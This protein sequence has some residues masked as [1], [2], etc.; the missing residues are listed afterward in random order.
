MVKTQVIV[1]GMPTIWGQQHDPLT[2]APVSARSYEMVSL[3]SRESAAV[4]SFL[5][6]LPSPDARAIAAV[7]HAA[8]WF[9]AHEIFGYSYVPYARR[10][11]A[12]AGPLWARM[13][14]IGTN[15]PIFSNREGIRLYDYEQLTD[16]KQGYAWYSSEP[17]AALKMYDDWAVKHPRVVP[18]GAHPGTGKGR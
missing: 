3:A 17:E 6:S 15:R 14:E 2:Y 1:N 13:S 9:R 12:G 16:R 18:D 10:D 11:S 5:M 8:D 7:H 4:M